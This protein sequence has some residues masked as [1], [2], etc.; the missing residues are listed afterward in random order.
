MSEF[1]PKEDRGYEQEEPV[2]DRF[3]VI[4]R[5]QVLGIDINASDIED[6]DDKE[7]IGAIRTY[8]NMYD[9]DEDDVLRDALGD[10]LALIREFDDEI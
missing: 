2:L 8:A 1:S 7:V 4:Y 10:Q 6:L 5:M 3:E 9:L